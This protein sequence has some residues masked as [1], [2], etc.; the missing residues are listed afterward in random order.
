MKE[1]DKI[2]TI[3][4]NIETIMSIEE[5]RIITYESIRRL[6]WYHPTKVFRLDGSSAFPID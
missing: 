5:H 1:G 2:I 6:C 3:Y 4:G